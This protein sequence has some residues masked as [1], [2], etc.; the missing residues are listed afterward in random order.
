M[1]VEV[2]A[3]AAMA[4]AVMVAADT[5]AVAIAERESTKL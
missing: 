1:A 2:T 4:A 3:A 5:A